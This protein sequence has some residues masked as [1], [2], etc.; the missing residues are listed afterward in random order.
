MRID[1]SK[2]P[3]FELPK[4]GVNTYLITKIETF[5]NNPK[6]S[7]S[8]VTVHLEDK[9]GVSLGSTRGQVYNL[10][11]KGGYYYFFQ[12]VT[13]GCDLEPDG[14]FDPNE[15]VGKFVD[16]DVVHVQVM[17]DK[18]D[19]NGEVIYDE[20]GDAVQVERTYANIDRIVGV[21]SNPWGSGGE[22][23]D[24]FEDDL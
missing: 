2:R 8:K 18:R 15:M 6:K 23:E 22:V 19:A 14:E 12:L 4:V 17:V 24:D 20:E 16:L 7:V 3:A 13:V 1:M 5:P 9:N 21:G 10:D 11:T